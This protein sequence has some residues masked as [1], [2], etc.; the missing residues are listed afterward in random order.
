MSTT[1]TNGRGTVQSVTRAF[2]ILEV[3]AEASTAVG[4]TE[5]AEQCGLPMPTVHRLLQT[6]AAGGYVHQTP[7]RRYALGARLMTLSRYAGGALGVA[8]RPMLATVV[9]AVDESAAVAVLDQDYARYISHVP[10][11]RSMRMFTEVG[12]KVSLHASGVGKAILSKMTPDE[13]RTAI[14]H[15]E[16]R[17]LTPTTITD[18]GDLMREIAAVQDRGY[19]IDD[20]EHETGVTCV[21]V[22]IP[23]PLY[24][25]ASISGPAGRM[26]PEFITGRAVPALRHLA[27]E[28][29]SALAD[30]PRF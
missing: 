8:L 19:A 23:G 22:P 2:E 30:Y 4:V 26:T 13:M 11:E 24:L 10:S 1:P 18:P 6:L 20:G 15:G 29:A 3:I 27:G 9:E 21:A 7:K 5:I 14:S 16:L 12:N 25:A 28:V 17:R